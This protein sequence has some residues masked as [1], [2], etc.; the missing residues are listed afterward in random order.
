METNTVNKYLDAITDK[1]LGSYNPDMRNY[2]APGEIMVTITLDEYRD[3]VKKAAT[4]K[5]DIDKAEADRY[6]RNEEIKAKAAEI[7]S[8]KTENYDLKK[9][10]EATKK[11]ADAWQKEYSEIKEICDGIEA[12]YEDQI[13][14]LRTEA[15]T[16]EHEY[17]K[18]ARRVDEL[19]KEV[20]VLKNE[21]QEKL[22][23]DEESGNTPPHAVRL[24]KATLKKRNPDPERPST[25]E[26]S[27]H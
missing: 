11:E 18:M 10:A 12:A 17:D 13:G 5:Q 6:Q 15:E 3:L 24:I 26:K 16:W 27:E 14:K 25:P 19:K 1:K 7:E 8:L 4:R 20:E 23:E 9:L 21:V 22:K 2:Q